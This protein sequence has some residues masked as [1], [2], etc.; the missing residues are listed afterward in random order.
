MNRIKLPVC[1]N[2]YSKNLK[3]VR[4]TVS[5]THQGKSYSV[6]AVEFHE[7]PDCGE[8]VYDPAAMRQIEQH[9]HARNRNKS[10]KR[11]A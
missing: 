2:C 11:I 5:G 8:R 1:P 6:P 3:R 10:A 9:L 7:C 4:K